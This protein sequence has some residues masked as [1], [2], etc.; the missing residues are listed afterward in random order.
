M[1]GAVLGALVVVLILVGIV[2]G[3]SLALV[4]PV[5]LVLLA[6]IFLGPLIVGAINTQGGS[7]SDAP[8]VP[9]TSEAS[10]DPVAEGPGGR[11]A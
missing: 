5:G 2:L 4:F 1:V 9:S 7:G 8:G 6:A 10:Y 3:W 11:T